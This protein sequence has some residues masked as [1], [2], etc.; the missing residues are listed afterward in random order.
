M[1]KELPLS[2][3]YVL[4][5]VYFS[6]EFRLK[7]LFKRTFNNYSYWKCIVKLVGGIKVF[8]T[9]DFVD[10]IKCVKHIAKTSYKIVI[11]RCLSEFTVNLFTKGWK[12]VD[13]GND[14]IKAVIGFS[15]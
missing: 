5:L 2:R 13:F 15:D 3:I 14:L 1:G 9:W 11:I 12:R 4:L 8:G 7:K 10:F 6:E